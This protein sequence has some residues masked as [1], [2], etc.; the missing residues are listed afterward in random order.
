MLSTSSGKLLR[1]R[2]EEGHEFELSPGA[3]SRGSW[4]KICRNKTEA[5]VTAFL[6][7]SP[8]KFETQEHVPNP[9]GS[10]PFRID[11]TVTFP[12]GNRVVV[13]LDGDQHFRPVKYWGG[14][15]AFAIGRA[16]D[17]YKMVYFLNKGRRIIRLKQMD[18]LLCNSFDWHNQLQNAL[19][20]GRDPI[21][22]L[23]K[24]PSKNSWGELRAELVQCWEM[25]TELWLDMYGGRL[26]PRSE[27]ANDN[28]T[29]DSERP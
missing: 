25:K 15:D 20:Y 24:D 1:F 11:W 14:Q 6:A 12:D 5:L 16:R 23:E 9:N 2:C 13:E 29:W 28:E 17:I 22:Y 27:D 4:C 26:L 19:L 18:V 7:T 21:I 3:V 8:L 10:Q